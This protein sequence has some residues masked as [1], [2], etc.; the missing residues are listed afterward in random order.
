[1][2][3]LKI[4]IVLSAVLFVLGFVSCSS[5][6][7]SSSSRDKQVDLTFICSDTNC[8]VKVQKMWIQNYIIYLKLCLDINV[9][10]DYVQDN[11]TYTV[12]ETTKTD[13]ESKINT[14]L[15]SESFKAFVCTDGVWDDKED[16]ESLGEPESS[17]ET[18][19]LTEENF[20]EFVNYLKSK[21]LLVWDKGDVYFVLVTCD[22]FNSLIE[23]MKTDSEYAGMMIIGRLRGSK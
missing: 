20:E 13:F 22:E 5:P 17:E 9:S 2:K 21:D 14:G 3:K 4:F 16:P 1:M 7:S 18:D 10:P 8:N 6:S 11:Y 12:S 19:E 23:R 15:N